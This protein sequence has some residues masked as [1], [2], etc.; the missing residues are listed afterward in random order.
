MG[1]L[2]P[3]HDGKPRKTYYKWEHRHVTDGD[4]GLCDCPYQKARGYDFEYRLE[5]EFTKFLQYRRPCDRE[6][7]DIT[8]VNL[9]IGVDWLPR[10]KMF[11]GDIIIVAHN[12]T[13]IY[14]VVFKPVVFFSCHTII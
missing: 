14:L 10:N 13:G 4:A 9:N 3:K 11:I 7:S 6:L 12:T 1:Q 2:T 5:A 8:P